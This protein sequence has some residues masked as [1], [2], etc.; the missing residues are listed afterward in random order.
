MKTISHLTIVLIL[1]ICGACQTQPTGTVV[2]I[3]GEQ[4]FVNGK[5]TYEGRVWNGHRIEGLLINSRMVQGVFDDLNPETVKLFA[6]PDT[7]TWD[8]D[9]NTDEFVEAMEKWYS[10]GMNSFTLNMQ[11]GS[12]TGYGNKDWLNPAFH[13]D[14]SLMD[15]YMLRLERILKKADELRMVVMLGFFYF[16]QDQHLEDEA[17]I[18]NATRNMV[19]W[20]FDRGYRN[21]LI[22]ICNES[23]HRKYEHDILMPDRVHE[24]INL[25]KGMERNGYHYLVT[26]SFTGKTVPPAN[27]VG[28]SDYLLIHGNGAKSHHELQALIDS[29]RN[30]ENFTPMPVVVN[31][32]DHYG[33]DLENNNFNTAIQNYVSWGY[34]DFRREGETDIKEG[35]QSVPV[36]WGVNSDRKKDF[37]NKVKEITGG[38]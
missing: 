32:D 7:K 12:P 17:A 13:K 21:V 36:D 22:E 28:V 4:F 29:T 34:F 3:K 37:F 33:Y 11:G 14:G 6:Y 9:R 18:T 25:V 8:A 38:N 26:T 19:N 10:Y 23:R 16:G 27:V 24:L 30:V 15:A 20:L 31:E 35:Y 5:P 2:E 1:T